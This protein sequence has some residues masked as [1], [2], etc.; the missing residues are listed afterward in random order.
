M[1][2]QDIE[3]LVTRALYRTKLFLTLLPDPPMYTLHT[4]SIGLEVRYTKQ[5]LTPGSRDSL[6]QVGQIEI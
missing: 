1:N 3:I 6:D 2:V 5:T 4:I